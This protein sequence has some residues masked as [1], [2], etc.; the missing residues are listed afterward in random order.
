[1]ATEPGRASLTGPSSTKDLDSAFRQPWSVRGGPKK[2]E[3]R[4][5]GSIHRGSMFVGG[6]VYRPEALQSSALMAS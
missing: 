1:M 3:H 4:D 5:K 6:G 2:R